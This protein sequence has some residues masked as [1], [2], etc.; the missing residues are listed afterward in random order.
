[1]ETYY[2]IDYENLKI[3]GAKF[4]YTGVPKNSNVI[5]FLTSRDKLSESEKPKRADIDCQVFDNIPE[6][7]EF[8]DKYISAYMGYL[9]GVYDK[10]TLKVYIVSRNRGYDNIIAFMSD[11]VHAERKEQ[12]GEKPAKKNASESAGKSRR[13]DDGRISKCLLEVEEALYE[14]GGGIP[15]QDFDV[16]LNIVNTS[17]NGKNKKAV[18]SEIKEKLYMKFPYIGEFYME[19]VTPAVEDYFK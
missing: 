5:F 2:L 12:I 8:V 3:A 9:A 16:V 19:V 15:R 17:L 7:K 6:G 18:L 13:S 11:L 4:S 14:Y 10:D 1:M